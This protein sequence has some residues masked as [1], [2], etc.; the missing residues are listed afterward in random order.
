MRWRGCMP[1]DGGCKLLQGHERLYKTVIYHFRIKTPPEFK[2]RISNLE[3]RDGEH[4]FDKG[5]S[6]SPIFRI[7][8]PYSPRGKW[9]SR[10]YTVLLHCGHIFYENN[11]FRTINGS[12]YPLLIFVHETCETHLGN[13]LALRPL[14]V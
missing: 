4:N 2:L 1:C 13:N 9:L 12:M 8:Y 14:Q 11:Q 3:F 5:F 10:P 6:K 7:L